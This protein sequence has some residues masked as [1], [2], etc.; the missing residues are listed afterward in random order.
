[1]SG[2]LF[3]QEETEPQ[4]WEVIERCVGELPYPTVPRGRWDFEGVI[5]TGNR[6]G[7]RAIRTDFDTSYFIAL[8]SDN[9]FVFA[10]QFSPDGRWFAYPTGTSQYMSMLWDLY[11]VNQLRVVSTDPRAIRYDIPWVHTGSSNGLHKVQWINNDTFT[12]LGR[13]QEADEVSDVWMINPFIDEIS[14]APSV[15]AEDA[16]LAVPGYLF[17][18]LHVH[19]NREVGF[20]GSADGLFLVDAEGSQNLVI[21]VRATFLSPAVSPNE[22]YAIFPVD[23]RFHLIDINQQVVFDLCLSSQ[24]QD[25]AWSPDSQYIAFTYDAYPILLNIETLEMQILRYETGYIIAWFA[26]DDN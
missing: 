16:D 26:F 5:I 6:D 24:Y 23:G 1:M 20:E 7:I 14:P 21:N 9:S 8:A 22:H 15:E 4:G 17:R 19:V 12:Y 25:V 10:G 2:H 11:R 3:A 13:P 18:D